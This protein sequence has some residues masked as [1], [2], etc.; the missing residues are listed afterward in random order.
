MYDQTHFS[1]YVALTVTKCISTPAFFVLLICRQ[2][3][4]K[5]PITRDDN[6]AHG[7]C[8]LPLNVEIFKSECQKKKNIIIILDMLENVLV[9][10][11]AMGV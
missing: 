2:R 10:S 1:I 9:N 6:R 11:S 5:C 7:D 8:N 3:N 4:N